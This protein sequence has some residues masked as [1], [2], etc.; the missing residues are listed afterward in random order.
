[1]D[2][3]QSAVKDGRFHHDGNEMT[4]WCFSNVVAR[5]AKKGLVSPIKAKP[6]QKIDGAIASI[7][8]AT[9]RH[10][11]ASARR[12]EIVARCPAISQACGHR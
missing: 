6:M 10:R 2:E 11:A 8:G 7:I 9:L 5:P 4:T 12:S 3:L 1:M